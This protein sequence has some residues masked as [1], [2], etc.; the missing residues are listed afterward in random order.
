MANNVYIGNRYVPLFDGNWVNNKTYAP[1]T[2]VSY[3]NNS[4]T[5]KKPV[6]L[7]TP[8]TTGGNDDPYWAL[9][10]NYNGQISALNTRV[11]ALE[12]DV[13]LERGNYFKNKKIVIYGDSISD[14]ANSYTHVLENTYGLDIT[15]RAI[16][17]SF[18][19]R[20]AYGGFTPGVET[21]NSASDL[22]TFDICLI[23]Y[24]TNDWQIARDPELFAATVDE[25]ISMFNGLSC[26]P[27]FI[28]PPYGELANNVRINSWHASIEAYID[29]AI[30]VCVNRHVKYINLLTLFPARKDS[31]TPWLENQDFYLHPSNMGAEMIARI[32]IAGAFNTGKCMLG[33]FDCS[34]MLRCVSIP[35]SGVV[36]SS[37]KIYAGPIYCGRSDHAFGATTCKFRYSGKH[38]YHIT[39]TMITNDTNGIR[40][41]PRVLPGGAMPDD[42]VVYNGEHIDFYGELNGNE[43]F[44]QT[45]FRTENVNTLYYIIKDF[46]MIV[47]DVPSPNAYPISVKQSQLTMLTDSKI[48][49]IN[50][51][52]YINPIVLETSAAVTQ[53][54]AMLE[55]SISLGGL[56]MFNGCY[57]DTS[58]PSDPYKEVVFIAR[59]KNI[60]CNENIPSGVKVY[61]NIPPILLKD[62]GYFAL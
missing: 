57:Y 39:G 58:T 11:T 14:R 25:V 48:Y 31:K 26:E 32:I 55:T 52:L 45:Y 3:G 6:P 28:L 54:T 7:N 21:I 13:I 34:G 10:G 59:D 8:P 20:P 5:S 12:G 29:K 42:I 62:S 41:A 38:R 36:P 18:L 9:T 56:F 15:N 43:I 44:L 47:D 61:I 49:F 37:E 23:Q 4:Y 22:N 19:T 33:T 16:A 24:G 30:D 51:T 35:D 46:S 1:L 2:I 60:Q 50:N 40:V 17:G 53:F 27:I